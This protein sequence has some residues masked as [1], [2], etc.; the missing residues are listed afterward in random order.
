MAYCPVCKTELDDDSANCYICGYEPDDK[1]EVNWIMIGEIEDKISADFAKEILKSYNIPAVIFSRS[2]FF[3]SAGLPLNP[4][5]KPGS[6]N[7]EVSVPENYREE[8]VDILGS[9]L[10]KK[11]CGKDK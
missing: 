7:F 3:G 5:Y 10:G 6:A 2:G 4:F 1:A 11:W 8:A 9:T